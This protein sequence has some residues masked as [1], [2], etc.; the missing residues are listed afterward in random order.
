[1]VSRPETIK[2]PELKGARNL[3]W[4]NRIDYQKM[5]QLL[6]RLD[7]ASQEAE[8]TEEFYSSVNVWREWDLLPGP[9]AQE[10]WG[11]SPG[12]VSGREVTPGTL[13]PDYQPEA[14]RICP[15]SEFGRGRWQPRFGRFYPEGLLASQPGSAKLGRCCY[16]TATEVGLD[17]THPL[18]GHTCHL[19]ITV[20]EVQPK[21]GDTGGLCQDWS[22]LFLEGP[23]QQARWR[24][25]PTDFFADEPFQR[26][27][28]NDDALFYQRPRFVSHLDARARQ[29][30]RRLYGQLLPQGG[31]V[32]DLMSSWQSHLP[33]ELVLAEVI[34]LGLN[35]AELRRNQ[36]LTQHLVHDLN[37]DPR[38]P[39]PSASF[40]GVICTA[41]VEYL[42]R[43]LDVFQEVARI[44]RPG[45][46][47][48]ITF[49][50]RWFPP[51]AIRIWTE[52]LD[53]ERLGLVA[54]Y[55]LR[56]GGFGRLKTFVSR[57]WPRPENDPYFPQVRISDPVFAIWGYQE[58]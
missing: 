24:G 47:F 11:R 55:F 8:H 51:K 16:L 10:L 19:M 9:W 50:N 40:D 36:R 31:R 20:A 34:G 30:I 45:G 58:L 26:Q 35:N 57:G 37:Q 41:S 17:F 56:S 27:D 18:A 49:S 43:P 13:L 12:F 52:L 5:V 48:I 39:W 32:L 54:E 44:L 53:Y 15:R 23:G 7:W 4:E 1:M 2:Q 28:E 3:E 38:L 22:A 6:W 25:Q 33:D 21:R 42:I 29:T 14:V 46:V